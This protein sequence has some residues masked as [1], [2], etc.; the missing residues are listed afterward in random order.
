MHFMLDIAVFDRHPKRRYR[1]ARF[2]VSMDWR[3]ETNCRLN[4]KRH[5]FRLHPRFAK[6]LRGTIMSTSP[7]SIGEKISKRRWL[8][9]A[10]AQTLAFEVA[11]IP[12]FQEESWR[13]FREHFFPT[14]AAILTTVARIRAKTWYVPLKLLIVKYRSETPVFRKRVGFNILFRAPFH[15]IALL[16]E[17]K[18]SK[19]TRF[20]AEKP[21]VLATRT[22]YRC[23]RKPLVSN[24]S[25][26]CFARKLPFQLPETTSFV[27]E[28]QNSVWGKSF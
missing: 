2:T 6:K 24:S 15:W 4:G 20:C 5:M 8:M 18:Y 23:L 17:R 11:E 16:G 19:G 14:Q 3:R 13:F 12:S 28:I 27:V 7:R 22:C 9:V 1:S 25:Q 10:C 21:P 26:M